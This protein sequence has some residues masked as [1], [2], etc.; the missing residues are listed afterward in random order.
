[1]W[2]NVSPALYKQIQA[3]AVLT[4]PNCKYV[5]RLSSALTADLH[6]SDSTIVYLNARMAN[7][8]QRELHVNLILDEV[9]CQKSVQHANG[10]FYGNENN[11]IT[12]TLLCVMI[13]SVAGSYRDVVAMSPISE[14]NH[15]KI[16]EVWKNVLEKITEVGFDVVVTMTDGHKSNMKIFKHNICHGKLKTS[17]SN[18]Y[19]VEKKISLLFDPTHLL[20]CVYNN[21]RNKER[22]LCPAFDVTSNVPT[23]AYMLIL[24]IIQKCT[25]SSFGR[26]AKLHIN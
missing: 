2:Q 20:K 1:M 8:C 6:L 14:I 16:Y 13:K 25:I 12:K 7:V 17:L 22:F 4:L 18:P 21:F 23:P 26:I 3:D 11:S 9:Y 10:G 24:H 15:D 5:R 19:D